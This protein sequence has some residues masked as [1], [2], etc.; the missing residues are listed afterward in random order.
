MARQILRIKGR[1]GKRLFV[2]S[3]WLVFWHIVSELTGLNMF[4][5]GL[6]AAIGAVGILAT[7]RTRADYFLAVQVLKAVLVVAALIPADLLP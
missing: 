7:Y 5:F 1:F 4:S 3:V 6:I 2:L